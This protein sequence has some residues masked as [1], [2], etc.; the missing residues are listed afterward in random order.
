LLAAR[1]VQVADPRSGR[2]ARL[3]VDGPVPDDTRDLADEVA[4]A[5]S[6]LGRPVLRVGAHDFLL[7]RSVRLERG[8]E[9]ADAGY[10][11]WFDHDALR[12]E[13]LDPLGPDGDLTW[14]PSLWD[15]AADRATR[16]P[17]RT[18]VPGSVAVVDGPFLLRRE[19]VG[20]AD[21][22]VHLV[23]SP[24]AR[25]RR[26]PP[27]DRLR[28]DGAWL[29][30]SDETDPASRADVVLAMDRPAHPAVVRT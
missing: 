25:A 27:G 3:V 28:V 13:V 2:C 5:V 21:V 24:S 1:A 7:P 11:R 29:R 16:E 9:D 18:A 22:A 20:T 14:L 8:P 23:V 6:A 19:L 26:L 17:R 15:A 4:E 10:E 30:Y 12:R